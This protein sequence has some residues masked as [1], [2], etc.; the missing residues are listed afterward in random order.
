MKLGK[1]PD[2]QCNNEALI[3]KTA[4][5]AKAP[6]AKL[7]IAKSVVSTAMGRPQ[8]SLRTIIAPH[9]TSSPRS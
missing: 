3:K 6:A 7:A 5:I 2:P 8:I 9:N 1:V 4:T